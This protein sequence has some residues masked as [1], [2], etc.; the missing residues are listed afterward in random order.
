L[1]NENV[2]SPQGPYR[3]K[4]FLAIGLV[5]NADPFPPVFLVVQFHCCPVCGCDERWGCIVWEA[6]EFPVLILFEER[7]VLVFE[8]DRLFC[9]VVCP[10]YCVLTDTQEV[11]ESDKCE[12]P[13]CLV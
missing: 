3:A 12:V 2:S 10:L 6:S 4:E 1:P 5:I 11:V 9:F 8:S 13:N 7:D